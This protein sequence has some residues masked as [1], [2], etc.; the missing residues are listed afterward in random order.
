MAKG[1]KPRRG[2]RAYY[3]RKRARS[4]VARIRRWPKVDK[5]VPLGFAGYKVGML[6]I[7]GIEMNKN[8]PFYGQERIYAATVL[9]VPPLLVV[10]VRLYSSGV[11]GLKTLSEIWS[12]QLPE[13]LKRVFTIPKKENYSEEQKK[14]L[15]KIEKVK[16]V[17][18]IVA[19]QPRKS[20]LGKKKPEVFEIAIGGSPKEALEYALGKLG[21]E[22]DISEVF[23]EGD[24]V[25]VISV[26]KGKGFQ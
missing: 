11:Y 13:D 12:P 10:G 4:I 18:L 1:H 23:K 16:E 19:T 17:R 6:H 9:E 3:P 5:V 21:K 20:G 14:I 7:V 8:S 26:T 15:E 24:Y 2:S 22:I 25:D